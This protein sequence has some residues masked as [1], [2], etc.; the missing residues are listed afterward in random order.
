MEDDGG[1]E[2]KLKEIK[3]AARE[4][5]KAAKDLVKEQGANIDPGLG[6]AGETENDDDFVQGHSF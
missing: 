6:A 1:F 2:E 4:A 5:K 3:A